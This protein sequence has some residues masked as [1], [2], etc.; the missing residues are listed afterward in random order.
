M[1]NVEYADYINLGFNRDDYSDDVVFDSTGYHPFELNYN[2]PEDYRL[3]IN[4]DELDKIYL[5][6]F[7]GDEF[8]FRELITKEV[9]KALIIISK[10]A[11]II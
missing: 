11:D 10:N 5:C 9:A 2:L 4:S 7:K 3:Y 6:K 1:E 8:I